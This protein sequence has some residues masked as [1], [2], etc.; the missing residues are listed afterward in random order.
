[1]AAFTLKKETTIEIRNTSGTA[2]PRIRYALIL[3]Q[4]R[5]SATGRRPLVVYHSPRSTAAWRR[6]GFRCRSLP[7]A[8]GPRTRRARRSGRAETRF[9]SGT[10]NSTRSSPYRSSGWRGT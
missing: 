9:T 6:P 4:S 10:M 5:S 8:A 3:P 7:L 2:K 1:M